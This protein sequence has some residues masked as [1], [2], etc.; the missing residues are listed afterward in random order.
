MGLRSTRHMTS[1]FLVRDGGVLLLPLQ[2]FPAPEMYP[3]L[4]EQAQNLPATYLL[5]ATS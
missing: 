3:A 4:G 1:V 2:E 5:T